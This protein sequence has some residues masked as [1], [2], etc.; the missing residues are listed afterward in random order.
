VERLGTRERAGF[1]LVVCSALG[2]AAMGVFAKLAY[3]EGL[4]VTTLLAVRFVLAAGVFWLL[5]ALRRAR[6]PDRDSASRP[7]PS[8]GVILA[9][10]GLGGVAYAAEAGTFFAALER[11]DLS[12]AS[13]LLYTY[14]A[15]VALGAFALGRER[16]DRRRLLALAA[17]SAGLVLVLAGAGTGALDPLGVALA[18]GAAIGYSAYILGAEGLSDRVDPWLMGALVITGAAVSLVVAGLVTG[19]ID[20][21]FGAAGW[22]IVAAM[23][24][25]S[26]VMAISCFFA[27]IERIGGSRASIVSTVE[28]PA[29]LLL[30]FLIFG[31]Q[32]GAVQLLGGA[33]VLAAIVVLHAPLRS[34]PSD[35]AALPADQAAARARA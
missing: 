9:G 21:G 13:L 29:T 23:A 22:L 27:G 24:L 16:P 15:L 3:D 8:R 32:L 31:E 28:P 25:I 33:L 12:L 20:L 34:R 17:A 6:T 4:G 18:L 7:S 14:P 10:L 35:P 26:T 1:A 19:A 2:F 5:L 30:A 11:I